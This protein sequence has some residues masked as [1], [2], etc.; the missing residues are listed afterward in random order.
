[1]YVN[2]IL[3]EREVEKYKTLITISGVIYFAYLPAE[4]KRAFPF[5]SLPAP[6]FFLIIRSPHS[7]IF[8][9]SI[10]DCPS[11]AFVCSAKS[12][13]FLG[14]T[15]V[16]LLFVIKLLHI[17]QSILNTVAEAQ[18]IL[19]PLL[20]MNEPLSFVVFFRFIVI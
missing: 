5:G 15:M 1:M 13:D 2:L 10:V 18:V 4:R 12:T 14:Q 16:S 19:S 11:S 3:L 8:H 17:R 20:S 6:A 7:Y 9:M